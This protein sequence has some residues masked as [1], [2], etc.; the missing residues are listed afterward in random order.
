MGHQPKLPNPV[1]NPLDE[2]ME[3]DKSHENVK[4]LSK[5]LHLSRHKSQERHKMILQTLSKLNEN[6][7]QD[8]SLFKVQFFLILN[9][10][11][12]HGGSPFLYL[13]RQIYAKKSKIFS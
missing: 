1:V 3:T 11:I 8:T 7:N 2:P 10:C 6:H 12:N 4:K 13:S 9:L 5:S